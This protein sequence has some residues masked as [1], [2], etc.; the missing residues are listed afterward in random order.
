MEERR[1][2]ERRGGRG[3]GWRGEEVGEEVGEERRGYL[4]PDIQKKSKHKTAVIKK[5]LNPE[6]NEVGAQHRPAPPSTLHRPPST[7]RHLYHLHYLHL[8]SHP[9]SITS[10]VHH[11]HPPSPPPSIASITSTFYHSAPPSITSTFH[12]PLTSRFIR[13]HHRLPPPPS[14]RHVLAS[15]FFYE[16]SLAELAH[17]TLEITVWDYDLGRSNDFIG[18]VCLSCHSQGDT[19]RHWTDCLKNRGQRVERWH[20]LTNELP[21]TFSHD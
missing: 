4:K 6:F 11:L 9:P 7:L 18:G 15:E 16:I 1:G 8:L 5:T 10:T 2:E 3:G 14:R 17:K 13:L 20:V 21:Q 19:L 12:H